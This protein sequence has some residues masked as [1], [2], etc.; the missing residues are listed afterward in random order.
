VEYVIEV[1]NEG[2]VDATSIDISDTL[3]TDVTFKSAHAVGF[4]GGTVSGTTTVALTGA[5][6]VKPTLPATETY[7]YLIIRATVN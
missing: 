6:L 4:S 3:P 1:K 2:S 7:G 5:T